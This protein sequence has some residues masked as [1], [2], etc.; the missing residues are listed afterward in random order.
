MRVIAMDLIEGISA[1]KIDAKNW[2]K[3]YPPNQFFRNGWCL[4]DHDVEICARQ[5][6]N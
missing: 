1:R 2:G 3:S 4:T 6:A 5:R